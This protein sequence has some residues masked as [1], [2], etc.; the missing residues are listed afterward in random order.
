MPEVSP[1]GVTKSF[2]NMAGLGSRRGGGVVGELANKIDETIR[3]YGTTDPRGIFDRE[4]SDL[5]ARRDAP[6]SEKLL[7][8][9]PYFCEGPFQKPIPTAQDVEDEAVLTY[10]PRGDCGLPSM[11]IR[12]NEIYAV[13]VSA[14]HEILYEAYNIMY[15]EKMGIR[16]PKLYAVFSHQGLNPLRIHEDRLP[17]P[18]PEYHYMVTEF[19]EGDLLGDKCTSY[20][21]E[22]QRKISASVG[23]QIQKLREIPCP[24][25]EYY[26]L[27]DGQPWPGI[28]PFQVQKLPPRGPWYSH[29]EVVDALIESGRWSCVSGNIYAKDYFDFQQLAFRNYEYCIRDIDAHA[30]RPV[31]AH[32]DPHGWNIIVKYGTCDED[33]EVVFV[34]WYSLAW[35]PAWM[36][37][38]TFMALGGYVKT[39]GEHDMTSYCTAVLNRLKGP[40]NFAVAEWWARHWGKA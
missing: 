39:R 10:K 16:T 35:V 2:A 37:I 25:P 6:L 34:D 21:P 30:R 33:F 1:E 8:R 36:G 15:L 32:L 28:S 22:T 13:K 38:G 7:S 4:M 20:N 17:S 29:D 27:L 19:I 11:V 40:E 23:D 5:R 18:L 26:G 24:H 31:L 3:C 9:I 14:M 12:V